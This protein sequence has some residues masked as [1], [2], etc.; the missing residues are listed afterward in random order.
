MFFVERGSSAGEVGG[1]AGARVSYSTRGATAVRC[2]TD[3][4]GK[5]AW[6]YAHFQGRRARLW[7]G[8]GARSVGKFA[9]WRRVAGNVDGRTTG[10]VSLAFAS[11]KVCPIGAITLLQ[12]KGYASSSPVYRPADTVTD[13]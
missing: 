7:V 13:P 4:T 10:K 11:G 3:R 2:A 12:K 5:V 6:R 9:G 8:Y 1:K